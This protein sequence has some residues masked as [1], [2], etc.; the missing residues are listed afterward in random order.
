MNAAI[1]LAIVPVLAV[2]GASCNDR[3]HPVAR[4][5][6]TPM[7]SARRKSHATDS[8]PIETDRRRLVA[9]IR[10][11][12]DM[13]GEMDRMRETFK[14]LERG[15]FTSDEHDLI[16]DL[17]FRFL[18]C[19]E[20]LWELINRYQENAA[21]F[22]EQQWT[23]AF[24]V[25]F[26]AAT[27]LCYYSSV[28]IDT[29]QDD[30]RVVAKLNEAFYRS[31]VPA[32]TFDTISRS[33]TAPRNLQRYRAAWRLFQEELADA[34]SELARLS[35]DN[36]D[37]ARLVTA[38]R[39]LHEPTQQNIKRIMDRSSLLLPSMSN[40]LRHSEITRVMQRA[41]D[42]AD[43]RLYAIR[44][45]TFTH[46]SRIRAP[47]A[48]AVRF[49]AEEIGRLRGVLE[50]GDLILTYSSGYMSN[51]FL[52][53]AF[54][55]GIT[56][57]G[58]PGQRR[59]V[60]LFQAVES[61]SPSLQQRVRPA[62]TVERLPDG[63][64]AELVEAVAEGVVFNSLEHILHGKVSR[65]TVIRP[66]LAHRDRV[67]ALLTVLEFLGCGYDFKFDFN[68]ATYQCCTEVIYRSLNRVGG[69]QFRLLSRAGRPT[70]CA[71]DICRYALTGP[72]APLDVVALA[73]GRPG[74]AGTKHARFLFGD[75]AR[76]RCRA[77]LDPQ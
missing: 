43:S 16:E 36:A 22:D 67:R 48:H 44:G 75:S 51:V 4:P 17:L 21:N 39:Q 52:P 23:R 5:G 68:D 31:D 45:L 54:K 66:S 11:L 74:S 62:L 71:D 28:L 27:H 32:G 35:R 46:V 20:S 50:P 3:R 25:A 8:L 12:S 73:E 18:A 70:L 13:R 10:A 63:S 49:T 42:H 33:L 57:V 19:R 6:A 30:S 76:T 53:G 40:M 72:A 58:S 59:A 64:P 56:Y 14:P 60:G 37:Y 69:I 55:H 7:P 9:L 38:V 15:H 1:G 29:F 65:L 61:L 2:V 26:S 77:L 41:L 24:V 47:G 34:D